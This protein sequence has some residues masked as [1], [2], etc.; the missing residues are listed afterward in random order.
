MPDV[1]STI[2]ELDTTMQDRL[3]GVL[4]T[5]GADPQ[6]Q[7]MRRVFLADIAFPARARVL[8]VGCGTGV[9][10]RVLAQVDEVDS[11]IGVDPAPSLLRRARDLAT[12]LSNITYRE[13]DGRSL[14]FEDAG[15]DVVVFDSTLSHVPFPER[16]L[17]EALRVLRPGG[18]LAVFDGDYA[19]TTVALGDH[20][21]LQV[22][23]DQMLANSVHDRW[24]MR[25]LRPLVQDC[26]FAVES[27]RSHGFVEFGGGYMLT[28]VE[29]GVDF[30]YAGGQIGEDTAAALK[31]EAQRRIATGTFFGHI[32][33][34]SLVAVRPS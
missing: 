26:G 32:A 1:Y 27:V 21:P 15:F 19:T 34:L 28:I 29:R 20:D 18:R 5:R 4:E 7:A 2:K 13:A 8:D 16:A 11:V 10:T 9:L 33:Y 3:A 14:P 17:A 31:A 30:L 6:Q 25:Q 24:L 22:C 23:V 12:D